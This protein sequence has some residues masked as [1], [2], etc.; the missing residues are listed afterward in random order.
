VRFNPFTG[1]RE[2]LFTG[3]VEDVLAISP[4]GRYA[5]L[6][7][8]STLYVD[9]PQDADPNT[10]NYT[11]NAQ[12]FLFDLTARQFAY[13][14][15]GVAWQEVD[16]F[17]YKPQITWVSEQTLV[18]NGAAFDGQLLTIDQGQITA[19]SLPG[20]LRARSGMWLVLEAVDHSMILYQ[21]K[22]GEQRPLI[23]A[24]DENDYWI[25]FAPVGDESLL[26]EIYGDE[27]L[28]LLVTPRG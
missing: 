26:V 28:T 2:N 8:D 21:W 9:I 27:S 12:A 16:F 20:N 23:K 5:V 13:H 15:V 24:H 10:S 25:R 22:T 6:V 14:F 19:T 18:M 17:L 4:T 1:E 11:Y 3:E 7:L